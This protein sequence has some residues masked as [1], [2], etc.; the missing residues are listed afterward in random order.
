MIIYLCTH[1]LLLYEV[2]KL[3]LADVLQP[4]KIEVDTYTE[5]N[6]K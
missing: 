1:E 5:T 4:L 2:N 6:E 3:F